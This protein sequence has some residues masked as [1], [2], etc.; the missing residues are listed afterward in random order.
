MS[1][2]RDLYLAVTEVVSRFSDS[3]ITLEQYLRSLWSLVANWKDS[4]GI[5]YPDFIAVL[6]HAYTSS[7]PPFEPSWTRQ[8]QGYCQ[9]SGFPGWETTVLR[10]IVD[11]HE[12]RAAGTFEN[13]H[14]YFGTSAPRGGY[15]VNF[16]PGS[17]L[18]C[19]VVGTFGGWE[20]GDETGRE[21]VPGPVAVLD[22]RGKI[23]SREPDEIPR[24][25]F[26][27][28]EVT[29]DQFHDFLRSGQHYE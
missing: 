25:V 20:P 22:D 4:A 5:P 24:P 8:H 9:D 2:N 6:E 23:V 11:L 18:E 19:G 14:R 27:L 26:E 16:D 10:Q 3:S 29:W 21:F 1:T 7:P 28:A 13:K 15:W 12:M 17:F